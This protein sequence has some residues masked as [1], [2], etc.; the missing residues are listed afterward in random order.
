MGAPGSASNFPELM[1]R[2]P[3]MPVAGPTESGTPS[4]ETTSLEALFL[5][6]E[7]GLLAYARRLV[8]S[9]ETAQ[10]IVQESFMRLHAHFDQVRQPRAWLFRTVHNLAMNH[11][12]S[13]RRE[14]DWPGG[15]EDGHSP[16]FPINEPMPDEVIMRMEAVGQARLC[17]E[18]LDER[19]RELIRLKFEEDLSYREIS[20]QTG[21]SVGNVGYILHHALKQLAATLKQSGVEL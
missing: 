16:E 10:D 1:Q 14:V 11:H 5:R 4:P 9:S 20:L 7:V 15:E 12:R 18:S 2:E 6:E 3:R 8:V 17:L 13:H 21:V 19:S